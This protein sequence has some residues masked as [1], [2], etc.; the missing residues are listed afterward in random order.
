VLRRLTHHLDERPLT[1]VLVLPTD[2]DRA[3]LRTALSIATGHRGRLRALCLSRPGESLPPEL[4]IALYGLSG[5]SEAD[6]AIQHLV[7]SSNRGA[8]VIVSPVATDED[9]RLAEAKQLGELDPN[10]PLVVGWCRT[11]PLPRIDRLRHLVEA[12]KGPVVLL[13]DDDG[14]LPT[15][16]L[17]LLPAPEAPGHAT[18]RTIVRDLERTLPA[19][20]MREEE[21][22][23]AVADCTPNTL[24]VA[25]LPPRSDLESAVPGR[26]ALVLAP[27]EQRSK[28][29]VELIEKVSQARQSR[30]ASA[31]APP[32]PPPAP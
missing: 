4:R 28:L 17:G 31:E 2:Q 14:P 21:A 6:L 24:V 20:V 13:V 30:A 29:V 9:E 3:P 10:V 8:H 12:F 22:R 27:S 25:G 26:L 1:L 19:F 18:V 16:V 32:P 7:A 23:A 5:R 15:E 11:G